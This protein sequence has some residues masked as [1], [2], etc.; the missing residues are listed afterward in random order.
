MTRL[1]KKD[2]VDLSKSSYDNSFSK[3]Y[4][5]TP[6]SNNCFDKS[7]ILSPGVDNPSTPTKSFN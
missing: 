5:T 1:I 2:T 6:K 7:V 4:S 3:T